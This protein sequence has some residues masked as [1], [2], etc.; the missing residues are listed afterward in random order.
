MKQRLVSKPEVLDR[1][2]VSYVTLWGWMQLGKFPRARS[3]GREIFWIAK[4]VDDWILSRP[5][6]QLKGDNKNKTKARA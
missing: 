2:G 5:L 1:V 4:E 3:V 6:T